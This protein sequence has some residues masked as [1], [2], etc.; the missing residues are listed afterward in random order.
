MRVY[1]VREHTR[2]SLFHRSYCDCVKWS[3]LKESRSITTIWLCEQLS[4]LCMPC[5]QPLCCHTGWSFPPLSVPNHVH[6]AHSI[7]PGFPM[8]HRVTLWAS[9]TGSVQLWSIT[10]CPSASACWGYSE[11]CCH[12]SHCVTIEINEFRCL[13]SSAYH[14][15][16]LN[17]YLQHYFLT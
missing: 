3:F 7:I 5:K 4:D 10:R 14:H 9:Q 12:R 17:F 16:Q 1:V 11:Y 13:P 8:P 15:L 6:Q 2:H